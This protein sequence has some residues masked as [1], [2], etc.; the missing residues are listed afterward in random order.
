MSLR[1]VDLTELKDSDSSSMTHD[2]YV[3]ELQKPR[4]ERK[5]LPSMSKDMSMA[6]EDAYRFSE[7]LIKFNCA[8]VAVMNRAWI[9]SQG[10]NCL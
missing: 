10:K 8:K 2:E 4:S 6:E 3:S 5:G 9:D 7:S 1:L